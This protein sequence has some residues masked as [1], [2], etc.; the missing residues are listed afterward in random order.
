MPSYAVPPS[1][2]RLTHSLRDVGY[3][4]QSALADLVDNS[5]AAGAKKV[6]VEIKFDGADSWVSIADD[7]SGMSANALHEALRFGSRQTY[8][9]GDLGRY[10]L[11]LKTAS[12]S[13]A[14]SVTVVTRGS[15]GSVTSRALDLD[16]ISDYDE[17]LI[18]DPGRSPS[19]ARSKELLAAGFQT[20]VTWDRLDRVLPDRNP[21]GGWARRRIE[22]KAEKAAAHL[23]MVFHRFLERQNEPLSITVNGQRLQPWD[24]FA[25]HERRTKELTPMSFEVEGTD[26]EFGVVQLRRF[27]LPARNQFSSPAAFESL[28]GPLKWNRQQGLYIYRADRLVQWGGWA[29]A[30]AIDEHTK[31]ARAALAFD[32]DLDDLFNTNVAKMR[33][34]LPAGLKQRIVPALSELCQQAGQVYRRANR[35]HRPRESNDAIESGR[36]SEAIFALRVA[37]LASGEAQALDRILT[38]LRR[39]NPELAELL[40]V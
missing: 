9:R 4:F 20:V 40:G 15:A 33:V 12:L 34:A 37:A 5:V 2:S 19:V 25:Q 31:L 7:G 32:T 10:G 39:D 8:G 26:G 18:V 23:S 16:L 24:P 11:G 36:A 28:A 22:A 35:D 30:R 38:R 14:R 17:W 29:G 3:D 6:S 13:Q 21:D 1:A 27:V